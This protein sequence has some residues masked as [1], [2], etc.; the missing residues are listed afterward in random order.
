MTKFPQ[1]SSDQS[2][3][4]LYLPEFSSEWWRV[5]SHAGSYEVD[6]DG[7]EGV[8]RE[9]EGPGQNR[10]SL[11]V[12]AGILAG[13]V[14]DDQTGQQEDEGREQD[15][16]DERVHFIDQWRGLQARIKESYKGRGGQH[17]GWFV[18]RNKA[19]IRGLVRLYMLKARRRLWWKDWARVRS[20]PW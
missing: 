19:I 15:H 7:V 16:P 8:G 3:W 1:Q 17:R 18:L 14:V 5:W 13:Q 2:P 20:T 12:E 6:V 11:D 10:K 4:M 9:G